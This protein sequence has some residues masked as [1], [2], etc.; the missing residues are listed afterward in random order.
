MWNFFTI[1][2]L[3]IMGK[4]KSLIKPNNSDTSI[5]SHT[6]HYPQNYQSDTQFL[7]NTFDS[8][9]IAAVYFLA[10]QTFRVLVQTQQFIKEG[11]GNLQVPA[12]AC[13]T[14]AAK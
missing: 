14:V 5:F 10:A 8:K 3:S 6:F 12:C 9:T 7:S 13:P 4:P 2:Q 1:N 11:N